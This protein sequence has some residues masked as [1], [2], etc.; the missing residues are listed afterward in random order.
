MI[1]KIKIAFIFLF[2]STLFSCA[3]TSH[4]IISNVPVLSPQ[5][6]FDSTPETIE[7]KLPNLEDIHNKIERF[8]SHLAQGKD[9]TAEDWTLHDELLRN[10][11]SLKEYSS[12]NI[13]V[14]PPHSRKKIHLQTF[15]LNP[16]VPAPVKGEKF[17]W[18]S[19][20]TEIPY[21][22]QIISYGVHS[23]IYQGKIQELIWNLKRGI[24]WEYY[25]PE[26]QRI[27]INIDPKAPLVL[28]SDAKDNISK[29]ATGFI[30]EKMRN[31][32]IF[33]KGEQALNQ[34]KNEYQSIHNIERDLQNLKSKH[35]LV[36]SNAL[37]LIPDT[38]IYA[39]T[40]TN[41]FS[42][43]D[44]TFYNPTDTPYSIN[45]TEH[46]MIS[47]RPDIQRMALRKE[48]LPS[49]KKKAAIKDLENVLYDDMVRVGIG[50]IPG[51]GDIADLYELFEGHKFIDGPAL[52]WQDRLLSGLGL[53][54]GSGE[55]YR[56]ALRAA[57]APER[58]LVVFEEALSKVF[59]KPVHYS[60]Q[61]LNEVKKIIS[62]SQM[63]SDNLKK[64]IQKN[65]FSGVVNSSK[66]VGYHATTPSAA[67]S[68]KK[69]GFIPSTKGRLGGKGVYV[70][71]S[72]EG[73][74][75]E[76]RYHNPDGPEPE[77]L[78]VEYEPGLEYKVKAKQNE[79][80][81]GVP[82]KADT[83]TTESLRAPGTNNSIIRNSSERIVK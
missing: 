32:D 22:R 9:L 75:A 51:V 39:D 14:I 58:Y 64:I 23:E 21:L 33:K 16:G 20:P 34:F 56:Y 48:V 6:V 46:Y 55:G 43:H 18:K 31:L 1:P 63:E 10:Y 83:L 80:S 72:S 36:P 2:F 17:L 65:E 78:K 11:I 61:D 8:R 26:T 82:V 47:T 15:C 45:L 66:R 38:E 42:S 68:I 62:T 69:G 79:V 77:I 57:Y 7:E 24:R 35:P 76:Y 59:K 37:S 54:F 29:Q 19:D 4:R 74:I 5:E 53:V 50:F 30:A 60:S 3:S 81:G 41:S 70:N 25:P 67:N 49:E 28:P 71:D 40:L 52:S 13:V 27:L 73:A 44:V 12:E